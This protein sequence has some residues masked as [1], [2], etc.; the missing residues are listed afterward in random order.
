MLV[1]KFSSGRKGRTPLSDPQ[2]F[3]GQPSRV[4]P[5][6]VGRARWHIVPRRW[7]PSLAPAT[8]LSGCG[9]RK[10][11]GISAW[12]GNRMVEERRWKRRA[13]ETWLQVRLLRLPLLTQAPR[14]VS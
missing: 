9:L 2:G 7:G 8:A 14:V 12:E 10:R 4:H 3:S 5:A 6:G 13:G 11:A 1:L